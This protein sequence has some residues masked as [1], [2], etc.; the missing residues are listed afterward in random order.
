MASARKIAILNYKGGTGKTAT[1]VNLAYGL[2]KRNKRVLLVDVDPQGSSG[3]HLGV[4]H[5]HTLYDLLINKTPL[6]DVVIQARPN[7]DFICSNEHL[8]PAEMILA[9]EDNREFVLSNC[10][11]SL[12]DGYQYI[13]MDCAPSMSLMSQNVLVYSDS[14]ILPVSMEYLSLL[15]VKQLLKNIKI[16]NRLFEKNV[17][18]SHVVPTFYDKRNKK[19]EDVLQSLHRVFHEHV[20]HP[21]RASID[22]SEAPGNKQTIYEYRPSSK[23]VEDYENLVNEVIANDG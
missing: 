18:I 15:G 21:I 19:S 10:L 2:A 7:L 12:E 13:L 20:T 23:S 11:D 4:K 8:F 1:A 5:S 14:V 22:I 3:H 16:I 9:R 6:Q 17:M